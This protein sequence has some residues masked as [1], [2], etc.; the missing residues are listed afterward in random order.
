MLVGTKVNDD[1]G[2]NPDRFTPRPSRAYVDHSHSS[3]LRF[4][5]LTVT[6][7]VSLLVYLVLPATGGGRQNRG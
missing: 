4:T 6:R 5:T 2:T 3:L 7:A 1:R